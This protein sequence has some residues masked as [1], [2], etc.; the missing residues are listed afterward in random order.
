M[1]W[2][3]A[4]TLTDFDLQ[5]S[6]DGSTWTTQATMT[7]PPPTTIPFVTGSDDIG[8]TLETYWPEPW[9]F[10]IP[11]APVSPQYMRLN[12]RSAS[13]GGEPDALCI[14]A[15][16]QGHP[17]EIYAIEEIGVFYNDLVLFP[18]KMHS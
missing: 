18:V 15:G 2:Q 11:S 14:A 10:E 8:C 3:S 12:T 4:G 5:I 13:Y 16:G 17:S 9:I 6:N 7:N 1:V